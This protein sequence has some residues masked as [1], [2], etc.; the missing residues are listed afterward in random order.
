MTL[1]PCDRPALRTILL[2]DDEEAFREAMS[3]ILGYLGF[4]PLCAASGEEALALVAGGARPA[5]VLLDIEMPGMGGLA[6]LPALRRLA[7]DLPILICT[8]SVTRQVRALA[9]DHERV[10]IFP[11][12]FGFSDLKSLLLA[13]EPW[14]HQPAVPELFTGRF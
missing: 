11:K 4:T 13:E 5:L 7:P 3:A 6:T 2:V 1:E 12:P 14:N 8:G 9:A 10:G